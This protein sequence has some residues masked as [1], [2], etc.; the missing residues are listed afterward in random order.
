M[1]KLKQ[2]RELLKQSIELNLPLPDGFEHELFIA[3]KEDILNEKGVA[4]IDKFLDWSLCYAGTTIPNSFYDLLNDNLKG[5]LIRGSSFPVDI[6]FQGVIYNIKLY[7]KDIKDRKGNTIQFIWH[8][9][10]PIAQAIERTCPQSYAFLKSTGSQLKD[11]NV[12]PEEKI[13]IRHKIN[14]QVLDRVTITTT[15]NPYYFKMEITQP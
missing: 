7:N 5:G 12:T 4:I 14:E 6:E 1:S 11:K 13:L 3:M 8:K 10:S 2:L 15:N 9:T